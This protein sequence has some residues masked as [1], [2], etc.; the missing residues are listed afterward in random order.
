[1]AIIQFQLSM[2]LWTAMYVLI[3]SATG[4][5]ASLGKGFSEQECY[6]Q[7]LHFAYYIYNSIYLLAESS[8]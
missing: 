4:S 2:P 1:M 8:Y 5:V 6:K 7:G 3:R